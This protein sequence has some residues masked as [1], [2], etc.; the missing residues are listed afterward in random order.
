MCY[1]PCLRKNFIQNPELLSVAK[2]PSNFAASRIIDRTA[3]AAAGQIVYRYADYADVAS[4]VKVVPIAQEPVIPG[5]CAVP[6]KQTNFC[7]NSSQQISEPSSP[8]VQHPV[9]LLQRSPKETVRP[10]KTYPLKEILA[11]NTDALS[12]NIHTLPLVNKPELLTPDSALAFLT[13]GNHL[14]EIMQENSLSLNNHESIVAVL[15]QAS[16]RRSQRT[17]TVNL[18]PPLR[19]SHPRKPPLPRDAVF[20]TTDYDSDADPETPPA[21]LGPDYSMI[22]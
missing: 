3:T 1:H 6:Q 13:S 20:T 17:T 19:T 14:H 18:P 12:P 7:W 16:L 8:S 15:R 22:N 10:P 5:N 21:S 4:K 9:F 11:I 2:P